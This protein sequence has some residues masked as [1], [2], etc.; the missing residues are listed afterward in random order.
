MTITQLKYFMSVYEIGSFS[1]A[2]RELSVAQS[3]ISK[4][5]ILLEEELGFKLFNRSGSGNTPTGGGKIMYKAMGNI[6]NIYQTALFE[7]KRY[8]E[9]S[10]KTTLKLAVTRNWDINP[11]LPA[12]EARLSQ[13]LPDVSIDIFP[14]EFLDTEKVLTRMR[15]DLVL[16]PPM[17]LD[18]H[19]IIR[20]GIC[21]LRN[22][23]LYSENHPLSKIEAPSIR[24]IQ[25]Y[26]VYFAVTSDSFRHSILPLENICKEYGF[27][28]TTVNIPDLETGV[29]NAQAGHGLLLCDELLVYSHLPCFR[30]IPVGYS[31]ELCV[32][33]RK[34]A[35]KEEALI[36]QIF[37]D[38]LKE[39]MG[40][41]Q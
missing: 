20:T 28:P 26:P 8:S 37:T 10:E 33:R 6:Q 5:I 39:L 13:Q 25:N 14:V 11:Y 36:Y 29:L 9:N 19:Q 18:D 17:D 16:A 21:P 1:A 35:S 40:S 23:L 31:F 3:A 41:D 34:N 12:V 2:A 24:D 32:Y 4:A 15:A 22:M 7:A 38:D 27:Q 30:S